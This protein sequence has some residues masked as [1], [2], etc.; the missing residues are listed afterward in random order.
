M[1]YMLFTTHVKSRLSLYNEL[2]KVWYCAL[3]SLFPL[4]MIVLPLYPKFAHLLVSTTCIVFQ[5][6]LCHAESQYK[7]SCLALCTQLLS[8]LTSIIAPLYILDKKIIMNIKGAQL[9]LKEQFYLSECPLPTSD[10][11][12]TSTENPRYISE[13]IWYSMSQQHCTS[14]CSRFHLE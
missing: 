7:V 2:E 11:N 14:L 1:V 8:V 12:Q 13:C 4:H 5:N 10:S 6:M 3:T 9:Q